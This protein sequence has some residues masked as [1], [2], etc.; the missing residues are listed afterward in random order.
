MNDEMANLKKQMQLKE[1]GWKSI[2]QANDQYKDKCYNLENE[3]SLKIEEIDNLKIQ[4]K[5]KDQMLDQFYLNRG[6][7]STHKIELE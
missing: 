6:A 2:H 7:E 4:L 5:K 3:I 1:E